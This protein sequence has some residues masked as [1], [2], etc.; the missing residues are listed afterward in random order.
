MLAPANYLESQ[1]HQRP[2]RYAIHMGVG[3]CNPR[4]K[5]VTSC[6]IRQSHLKSKGP[7]VELAAP[8]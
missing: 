4:S 5:E 2:L 3:D 7:I 1:A 6:S 8:S